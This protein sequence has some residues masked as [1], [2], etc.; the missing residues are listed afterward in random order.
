MQTFERSWASTPK[1]FGKNMF[2]YLIIM[3]LIVLLICV[4]SV[5]AI[6]GTVS[7]QEKI[8]LSVQNVP[9]KKAFKL[10]E[11]QTSF[12]FVYKDEDLSA[13][14]N[15][16]V[17]IKSQ[18]LDD[19]MKLLLQKTTLSYKLMGTDLVVIASQPVE[20]VANNIKAACSFATF[21]INVPSSAVV[22]PFDVCFSSTATLA[23]G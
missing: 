22:V 14:E 1:A 15:V 10:I 4:F 6:G 7:A 5:S 2:K 19:V 8:S 11:S 23:N 17:K 12:R 9:L 3:K 21:N 13:N 18:L 16:S 20:P